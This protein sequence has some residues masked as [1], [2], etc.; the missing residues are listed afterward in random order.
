LE[1]GGEAQGLG[2]TIDVVVFLDAS[3]VQPTLA[4]PVTA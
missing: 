1:R 3:Y 4:S 2:T